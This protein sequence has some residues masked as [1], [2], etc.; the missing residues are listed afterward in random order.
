MRSSG[1]IHDVLSRID[2]VGALESLS[3][4]ESQILVGLE[5]FLTMRSSTS[6]PKKVLRRSVI[7]FLFFFMLA[8][9]ASF[10][11][12]CASSEAICASSSLLVFWIRSWILWR[13]VV[14]V[15]SAGSLAL[16]LELLLQNQ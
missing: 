5:G 4:P 8:I 12:T 7:C 14:E 6:S 11:A 16:R 2:V 1:I 9:F 13:F 3:V 15:L 10:L